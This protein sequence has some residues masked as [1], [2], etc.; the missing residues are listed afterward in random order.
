MKRE[1]EK[2]DDG[3]G[4]LPEKLKFYE[5]NISSCARDEKLA[6]FLIIRRARG[7]GARKRAYLNFPQSTPTDFRS[8]IT[9][10][11][12]SQKVNI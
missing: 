6:S 2:D 9:N 11:E 1:R 7:K 5:K 3:V 4:V 8:S 12:K 10:N